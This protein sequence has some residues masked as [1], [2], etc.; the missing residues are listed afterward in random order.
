MDVISAEKLFAIKYCY[1]KS[2]LF[3]YNLNLFH[4]LII[5]FFTFWLSSQFDCFP[6]D[7]LSSMIN[8]VVMPPSFFSPSCF[9]VIVNFIV[10]YI[11]GEQKLAGAESSSIMNK[12]YDEYYIGKTMEMNMN[13]CENMKQL[14]EKVVEE[15]EEEEMGFVE[16]DNDGVDVSEKLETEGD[17]ELA[18]EELN[19]RAEA[20]IARVNKQRKLEAVDCL[21]SNGS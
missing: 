17:C 21:T 10:I 5:F 12:M 11:V 14:V 6:P 1:K 3:L 13:S 2:Q 20:F 16:G 7:A 4:S 18:N 15:K 8:M 19:K 9:F